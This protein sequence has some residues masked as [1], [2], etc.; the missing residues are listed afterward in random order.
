MVDALIKP[1]DKRTFKKGKGHAVVLG[2]GV[3]AE[4]SG[5][6]IHIHMTGGKSFH[7]T[8]TNDPAS[9]RYHRTLFWDLREVLI[10][11]KCWPY[12]DDGAETEKRPK[13][14]G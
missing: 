10:D 14:I 3:W 7:T 12:G 13:S 9:E 5:K 2:V 1:G 8:V 6:Q 11:N 4:R